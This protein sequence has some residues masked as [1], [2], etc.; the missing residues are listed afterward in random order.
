M[1]LLIALWRRPSSTTLQPMSALVDHRNRAELAHCSIKLWL[2][3]L[4]PL[5]MTNP[6]LVRHCSA[7]S[8]GQWTT[9]PVLGRYKQELTVIDDAAD[10]EL[11]MLALLLTWNKYMY[12]DASI[13]VLKPTNVD[14]QWDII[15]TR[16]PSNLRPTTRECV[17]LVTL[18]HFRLRDKDGGHT[19]QFNPP[20]PETLCHTRRVANFMALCFVEPELLPVE[21]L[22]CWNRVFPTFLLLWPWS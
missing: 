17:R 3:L 6:L 4:L 8:S 19:I 22:H 2:L 7:A 15:Q 18:G 13:Y 10:A 20:Q 11:H 16:F 21:V 14:A 5:P 1:A 9:R 12:L